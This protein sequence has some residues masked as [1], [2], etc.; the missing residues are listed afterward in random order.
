MSDEKTRLP[1]IPEY[2]D[3]D[4]ELAACSPKIYVSNEEAAVLGTMR[5]LRERSLELRRALASAEEG[6]RPSLES[7]LEELRSTWHA[8]AK[9]REEAFRRKM[10]M[11]GHLPPDEDDWSS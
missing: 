8:L 10:I 3:D 1:V 4:Q 7:E 2:E 9:R 11:L 5:S 6:E